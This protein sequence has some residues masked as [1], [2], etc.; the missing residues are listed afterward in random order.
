VVFAELGL[1]CL[2]PQF[3]VNNNIPESILPVFSDIFL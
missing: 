1:V 3:F 2:T